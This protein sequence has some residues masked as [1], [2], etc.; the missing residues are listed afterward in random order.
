VADG[1]D[2]LGDDALDRSESR[3]GSETP[4]ITEAVRGLVSD[5]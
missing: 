3:A 2:A 1:P 4:S 5:V